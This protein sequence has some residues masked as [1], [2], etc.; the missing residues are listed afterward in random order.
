MFALVR[1]HRRLTVLT[2]SALAGTALLGLVAASD[3][4]RPALP[5]PLPLAAQLSPSGKIVDR[6]PGSVTPAPHLAERL[7]STG[8]SDTARPATPAVLASAAVGEVVVAEAAVDTAMAATT[9]A[10]MALPVQRKP[11]RATIRPYKAPAAVMPAVVAALPPPRPA[12]LRGVP[13]VV[14]VASVKERRVSIAGR[15]VAFVG[16]LAS[17]ARLL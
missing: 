13:D 9:D 10:P 11:A 3:G 2:L 12:S 7:A 8:W 4:N 1:H 15:M 14:E 6:L 16:S 17:F 5:E